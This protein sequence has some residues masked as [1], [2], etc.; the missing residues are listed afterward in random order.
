MPIIIKNIDTHI[1]KLR[2]I[3]AASTTAVDR[4]SV[5]INSG[6]AGV[7]NLIDLLGPAS[8]IELCFYR[9][10]GSVATAN[11]EIWQGNSQDSESFRC[12]A[13][14]TVTPGTAIRGTGHWCDSITLT[15]T[16]DSEDVRVVD[17]IADDIATLSYDPKDLDSVY[18]VI[19]DATYKCLGRTY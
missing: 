6:S 3:I 13:K 10:S 2:E 12:V 9:A 15:A 19:S 18:L 7:I 14:A 8:F 11:I 5:E 17:G 4:T 1:N 16:S